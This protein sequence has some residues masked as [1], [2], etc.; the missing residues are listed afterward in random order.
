MLIT[1]VIDEIN[2]HQIRQY[3]SSLTGR[4]LPLAVLLRDRGVF[5]AVEEYE[6]QPNPSRKAI[7]EA[8]AATEV[9]TWRHQVISDLRHQGVLAMD[10]FPERLTSELVNQYLEIKARHL[11]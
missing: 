1:N 8:A 7:Y 9:L 10:L 5:A 2:S 4:H 11:L 6:S 3:L